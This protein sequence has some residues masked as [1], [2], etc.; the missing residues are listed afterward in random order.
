[1]SYKTNKTNKTNSELR[2]DLVSG[3]W[4]LIAPGRGKRP[5]ALLADKSNRTNRIYKTYRSKRN[6][7]FENP[8]KSGQG[9]PSLVYSRNG[10]WEIQVI[11]NKYPALR[12][13]AVCAAEF[14]VGPYL[15]VPGIGEQDILVTRDHNRNFAHL[16]P[17]NAELVFDAFQKR[18]L[19]FSEDS[20]LQYVLIFHNWGPAAG[21]SIYHPHYQIM[22]LPII[23]PDIAH[24][25]AGSLR[26]F[27]KHRT[28]VHCTMIKWEKEHKKRIV[29]EN[30]EAIVVAPFASRSP[31]ELRVYPKRHLPFF[32][33]TAESVLRDTMVA[34]QKT[35]LTVEKKLGDPD[36]NFFIHTSPLKD[37]RQY[38]HY[39]W[40][41]EVLPKISVPAGFELGTGIE[42]NVVDP[43]EAARLLR[44]K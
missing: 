1:M 34:L 35:L 17:K 37:K 24:S 28:C 21:A 10:D 36:Y 30:K 31:Y 9:E 42:I 2:Q 29:Y 23:P 27:R 25:L 6:C 15:A 39:H 41:I 14:K 26:F 32:R 8:E 3:D 19:A 13:G 40:H 4:I 20:C 11:K 44:V 22:A 7:P 38:R 18:Y 16:S 43:D 12:H 33:E 5:H